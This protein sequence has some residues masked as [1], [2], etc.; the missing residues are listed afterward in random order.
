[1]GTIP[2]SCFV[3]QTSMY[4]AVGLSFSRMTK[5]G[6]SSMHLQGKKELA[7]LEIQKAVFGG[8]VGAI[9][10]VKCLL[11]SVPLSALARVYSV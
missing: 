2:L 11:L 4:V 8:V 10:E 3:L 9:E 1:M 5:P 6:V 7:L